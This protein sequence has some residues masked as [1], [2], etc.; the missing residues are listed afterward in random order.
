MGFGPI[1]K[2]FTKGATMATPYGLRL[3]LIAVA[4]S[5]CTMTFATTAPAS[6]FDTDGGTSATTTYVDTSNVFFVSY[7]DYTPAI[8]FKA[9]AEHKR[10]VRDYPAYRSH[11]AKPQASIASVRPT[12]V[13]GWRS[14]RVRTLAG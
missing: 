1:S 5:L 4:V 10:I 9:V 7:A 14:G 13:S 12:S 6:Y 11:P 3:G 2:P 8:E